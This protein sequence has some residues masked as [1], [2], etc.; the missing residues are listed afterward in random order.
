MS[1]QE[2]EPTITLQ[3]IGAAIQIIDLAS[4]RGAIRGEEM[5][6]V[7]NVRNRLKDFL[8]F[9]EKQAQELDEEK[10]EPGPQSVPTTEDS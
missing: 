9:S 1:E 8:D 3:D 4:G 10:K 2:N 6:A 7:G 5:A